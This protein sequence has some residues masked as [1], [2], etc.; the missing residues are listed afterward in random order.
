MAKKQI[1]TDDN[2]E[3][4]IKNILENPANLS[5]FEYRRSIVPVCVF[6]ALLLVAML[7]FQKYYKLVLLVALVFI[8]AY[9]AVDHIRLK[10]SIKR[11]SLDDYEVSEEVVLNVIEDTY[12]TNNRSYVNKKL[13]EVRAYIMYFESGKSWNIPKDNYMWSGEHPMSDHTIYQSVRPHDPFLIVTKK[14]TG[15]IVM[16]YPAEYFAYKISAD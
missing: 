16:A 2:I 15:E 3:R 14:D 8:I 13:S 4:D 11:V 9:L 1:L 7:V 12:S 6:S 10:N 5:R